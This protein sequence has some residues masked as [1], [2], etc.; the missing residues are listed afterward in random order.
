[1][2]R[3]NF[4]QIFDLTAKLS[5]SSKISNQPKVDEM[6]V[7]RCTNPALLQKGGVECPVK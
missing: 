6:N 1:M 3:F 4:S 7:V 2:I 5:V